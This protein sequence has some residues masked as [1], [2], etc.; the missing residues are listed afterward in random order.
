MVFEY[1]NNPPEFLIK[2]TMRNSK[3]KISYDEARKKVSLNKVHLYV[4]AE[5]EVGVKQ[6]ESQQTASNE[7]QKFLESKLIY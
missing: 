6:W 3:E 7:I 1:E 5:L 2:E 4:L